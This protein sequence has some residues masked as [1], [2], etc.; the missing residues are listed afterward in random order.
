VNIT[1]HLQQDT[2]PCATINFETRKATFATNGDCNRTL[3]KKKEMDVRLPR[4]LWNLQYI[5]CKLGVMSHTGAEHF[6]HDKFCN[7]ASQEQTFAIC[8]YTIICMTSTITLNTPHNTLMTQKLIVQTIQRLHVYGRAKR[9]TA[10]GAD[11]VD[12]FTMMSRWT[13]YIAANS[14][15]L[16][17]DITN[18]VISYQFQSTYICNLWAYD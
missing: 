13:R 15:G 9:N 11:V 5:S 12:T 17:L 2:K 8:S 1:A 6:G 18:F 16:Y 7:P 10:L 4:N 14:Q 3:T